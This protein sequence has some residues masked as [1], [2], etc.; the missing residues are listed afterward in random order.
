MDEWDI[1]WWSSTRPLR[2][3]LIA[4]GLDSKTVPSES[5]SGW[6]AVD[7]LCRL[8]PTKIK[9][10]SSASMFFYSRFGRC[11]H[12]MN[13]FI[14]TG[15]SSTRMGAISGP[16]FAPRRKVSVCCAIHL[17]EVAQGWEQFQRIKIVRYISHPTR[18]SSRNFPCLKAI[19]IQT[20]LSSRQEWFWNIRSQK[21]LISHRPG[22]LCGIHSGN[23]YCLLRQDE[24]RIVDLVACREGDVSAIMH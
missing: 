18:T 16:A 7:M 4:K 13:Y 17:L 11:Y 2:A 19:M 10:T 3:C 20:F 24:P 1:L 6:S 12:L 22:T 14:E 21:V 5:R 23:C 9:Q 15:S 8:S